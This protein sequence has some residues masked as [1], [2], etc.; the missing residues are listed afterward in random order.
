MKMTPL[1]LRLSATVLIT[2]ASMD[3]CHQA[4]AV[5]F[6]GENISWESELEAPGPPSMSWT[7]VIREDDHGRV[8]EE[9]E[10]LR[11][12]VYREHFPPRY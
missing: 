2:Y 4:R 8:A 1:P 6:P 12:A 5:G 11:N 10:D 9:L 7:S 3:C